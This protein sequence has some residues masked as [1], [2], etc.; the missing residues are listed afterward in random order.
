MT[1]PQKKAPAVTAIVSKAALDMH[2]KAKV[3]AVLASG[4]PQRIGHAADHAKTC[5]ATL[6]AAS[7]ALQRDVPKSALEKTPAAVRAI[8]RAIVAESELNERE[9]IAMAAASAKHNRAIYA[10]AGNY[11]AAMGFVYA[12]VGAAMTAL[13]DTSDCHCLLEML[14]GELFRVDS[15]GNI[16]LFLGRLGTLQE[17]FERAAR[18]D[19]M[20]ML[21]EIVKAGA[22]G[23]SEA[24]I[25]SVMAQVSEAVKAQAQDDN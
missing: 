7:D 21:R 2:N 3:S 1:D 4:W 8:S 10:A 14:E 18:G 11:A 23:I 13:A 24:A 22:P 19:A 5:R 12:E 9:R 25:E 20:A 6:V 15:S 17:M 16:P